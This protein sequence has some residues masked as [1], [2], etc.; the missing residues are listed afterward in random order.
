MANT[1]LDN[2]GDRNKFKSSLDYFHAKRWIPP[3]APGEGFI[4]PYEKETFAVCQSM[5]NVQRLD[6]AGGCCKYTCKYIAKIDKQNYIKVSMN[7]K[8][9]GALETNSTY[10]HNTKIVSSDINRKKRNN[11]KK[12]H[13][14]EIDNC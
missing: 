6:Q 13:V 9:K 12:I 8:K 5:Q 10:L 7:K 4:S 11:K 3:V 1:I 2:N 14:R